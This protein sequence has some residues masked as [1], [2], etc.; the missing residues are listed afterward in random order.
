MSHFD[1]HNRNWNDDRSFTTRPPLGE[2]LGSSNLSDEYGFTERPRENDTETFNHGNGSRSV[3]VKLLW[4]IVA[5]EALG[6][7]LILS[8]TFMF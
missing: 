2:I 1:D 7:G 4:Y 8:F 3:N 5:A 6:V